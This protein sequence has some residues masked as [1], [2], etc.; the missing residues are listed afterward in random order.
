M[1]TEYEAYKP[2]EKRKSLCVI[3]SGAC[4]SILYIAYRRF[5]DRPSLYIDKSLL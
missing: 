2:I 4:E 5:V 1:D 3:M